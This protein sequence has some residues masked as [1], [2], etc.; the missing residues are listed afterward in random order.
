MAVTTLLQPCDK[1]VTRLDAHVPC[2]QSKS[3]VAIR[4]TQPW[5]YCMD[6]VLNLQLSPNMTGCFKAGTEVP[7]CTG[8][9]GEGPKMYSQA[10]EEKLAGCK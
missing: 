2:T 7:T 4:L 10:T 8:T 3:K 5:Y 1:V 6:K 9:T